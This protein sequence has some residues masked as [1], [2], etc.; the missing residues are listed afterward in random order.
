MTKLEGKCAVVSGGGTGLGASIATD[1]ADAG[2]RVTILGRRLELLEEIAATH[3]AIDAL[4]CDVT[5]R[6]SVDTAMADVAARNGPIDIAVANAGAA[7]SKPFTKM[8][9]GDLDTMLSVNL[10]G[11][12]HLWQSVLPGMMNR[13]G[14]LIVIASIAGLRGAAYITS[15]CTA[16]HGVVGLTRALA[17]EVAGKGVTVNAV[18]PGYVETPMLDRTLDNIVAKTGMS[19]EEA[20]K[21]LT[22]NNPQGRFIQPGEVARTVTW[23]CDAQSRSV[24]GQAIVISGG[25][26]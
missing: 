9:A 21:T 2:A 15:Y 18:C 5:D 7:M 23:L 8:D 3:P 17:Q 13:D 16:K 24:N 14:R 25:E 12:F 22:A 26:V 19:R 6:Q 1:L 20:A 10:Y 4:V 11:V